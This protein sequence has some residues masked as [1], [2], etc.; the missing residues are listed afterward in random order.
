MKKKKHILYRAQRHYIATAEMRRRA[1]EYKKWRVYYEVN[2][3]NEAMKELY[4]TAKKKERRSLH[5][6]D[7]SSLSQQLDKVK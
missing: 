1:A 2:G 6:A 7:S 3:V 5:K 4:E